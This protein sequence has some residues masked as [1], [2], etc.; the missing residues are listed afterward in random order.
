MKSLSI[1]CLVVLVS[2]PARGQQ[3][4]DQCFVCHQAI[5]SPSAKLFER[6]VHHAKGI[7]CAGCH[8]GSA[9]A[10]EM[11]VGMDPKAGFIGVPKGDA[12]SAA[13]ERCH[14][15]ADRMKAYGSKLPTTQGEHLRESMHGRLSMTGK[16]RLAQC[17]TCHGAHGVAR[18]KDKASPVHPL[19]VTATCAKC[20]SSAAFMRNYNPSLPIDQL[21]KYKTS[22]HGV[23]HARGDA[24]VAECASCHGSHEIRAAN[25]VKSKTFPTNL[26]ATCGACHSD[27]ARMK[28]Y[29]IPVDQFEKFARSVHGVALLEKHDLGAP[30]CNDC[31]GNHGATPPGVQ[32]VSQ[33]C[34][35]CHA[36]NADLFSASPHKKAF[37]A[38]KLPECETCH[39]NHEIIAATE[40]LLGTGSGAVCSKCHSESENAKG[41]S[42]ARAMRAGVDSLTVAEE[43]A[44]SLVEE[45]EQK[46]MEISEEKFKLREVRQA[47]LESRT[48]VHAFNEERLREVTGKGIAAASVISGNAQ[49]AIDE[50]YF[51]RWGLGI[52][53]III[54]IVA[55][56]LYLTIRQ[57]ERRQ[58]ARV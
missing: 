7:S 8:G 40:S 33:V 28:P 31:H 4:T 46:G 57:I 37:D 32:S 49:G 23:L 5:E 55:F 45:A 11:E 19:N 25:D 2:L 20:H 52:S 39:G 27:A 42:A 48:T 6:D 43:L 15:D 10:E 18:V 13:C 54:S 14:S 17:T 24:N 47:R 35:T 3:K 9:Q 12:I 50:Y 58:K 26:P 1:L 16:E 53:T 22:V 51:R 34:G 38:R 30:A 21:E 29:K 56:S 36:L 41:F 44:R